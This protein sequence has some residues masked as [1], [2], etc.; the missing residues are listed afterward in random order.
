M[1]TDRRPTF[2]DVAPDAP[3]GPGRTFS[4][5]VPGDVDA[6]PGH[7]V[8]VPFGPRRVQGL[9]FEL[10]AE[11]RVE[12]T[13]PISSLVL[14]QPVLS[15]PRLELARWISGH[16]FCSLFEAASPMLPPGER[17]RIRSYVSLGP[18][19]VQGSD[20]R[21]P[22]PLQRRVLEY[23][24]R[25]GSVE[26]GRLVRALGEPARAALPRMER[27]GFLI[28]EASEKPP[29]GPKLVRR[30][31]LTDEGRAVGPD[32][33]TR[34]PRQAA[35]L[36]ALRAPGPPPTLA[37]VRKE[38]GHAA[39]AALLSKSWIEWTEEVVDRDP[40]EGRV[41][42]PSPPVTL[43]RA[44][45][46]T[47]SRVRSALDGGPAGVALLLQ[48]VTGS[49]KTE[50][51][52]DAA[53]HCL[54][55]GRRAIVLVPEIALTH[56]TVERFASR[57][58]GRVAV[59]HSGLT[60][61]ERYDQWRK[62][63]RGDYGVVVGSRSAIFAP[64]PDLGLIVMDEEHEWTYKQAEPN[65]RYH[66]RDVAERLA[67]LA[68]AVVLLGSASPDVVTYDRAARGEMRLLT[69]PER[70]R[71]R[72]N[73][74]LGASDL[75][76][77]Q[78]VDMRRELREGNRDVFSRA[79]LSEMEECLGQGRQALL[80]L[81]RRGTASYVQCRGCGQSVQCRSCDVALT[82][83]RDA[84]RL[85]CHYCG[86]REAPPTRCRRCQGYHLARYGPGTESV[87]REVAGRFPGAGVIRWDRDTAGSARA[88]EE[89]MRSFRQRRAQVLVGTQMIAKGLHFPD[90]SLVGVV[91]ADV[92]LNVPD[93]RAG[94]R[95]FQ[96]L[97]Q[98]AGRAGRG[99]SPGRVVVQ[100]YQPDNYAVRAAAAQDY[101]A[102]FRQEMAFRR[103]HSNPPAGRLVRLL[104]AHVNRA[105]C[106]R[107]AL[108]LSH[109]I[110]RE[111][112]ES[113]LSDVRVLGPTPA[114][115]ERLRG[116]CRWHLLLRGPNPRPLLDNIRIP[117]GW[118]VDVD[119]VTLT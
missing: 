93:Y 75:A 112:D 84:D 79:L 101:P 60:A 88:G 35:L 83:H 58:P 109:E 12:Q 90:V 94:E 5:S 95:A 99:E 96:L 25:R 102:F 52:L 82:Y 37:E 69:L 73:R 63:G 114:F 54:R 44:Q 86:R 18:A 118:T 115:P 34:A 81:N 47:A 71:V 51:Y 14:P 1:P 50:I 39:V 64:Q 29:Q 111:A 3:V 78:V 31:R 36:D 26:H 49:G 72:G 68:G 42:P 53:A 65:P 97:C 106:E 110:R 33:I 91:S 41:F 85:L 100:T 56:Q 87:A 19:A 107:E 20:A 105:L 76:S 80:F 59:L 119:P 7:L 22:T 46:A 117:S 103:E 61:G 43:T 98:V 17:G 104:Y 15:G 4:Y 89:L 9:V 66:A 28:I 57:F 92:G 23:V 116:R 24:G 8:R 6:R 21:P 10:T 74:P 70:V 67:S 62:I 45:A 27:R 48:G 38:H 113:P 16:Y 108:R 30:V 55:L 11:P 32:R 13:R 40:L 77:V 2:A